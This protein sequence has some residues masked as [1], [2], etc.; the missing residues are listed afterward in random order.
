MPASLA[1]A[2]FQTSEISRESVK[3]VSE[4]EGPKEED[5]TCSWVYSRVRHCRSNS[6]GR[7]HNW[8]AMPEKAC[9][10]FKNCNRG[11]KRHETHGYLEL[12]LESLAEPLKASW[13]SGI[14]K[15]LSKR[16]A[17]DLLHLPQGLVLRMFKANCVSSDG[18]PLLD[19]FNE[20]WW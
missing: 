10:W 13:G 11:R 9:S 4:R 7:I 19:T 3:R 18:R 12:R 15:G 6:S 1:L 20:E 5:Y 14:L 16:P 17:H 8:M 2:T